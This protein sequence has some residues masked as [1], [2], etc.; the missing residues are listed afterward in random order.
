[1]KQKKK[2][3]FASYFTSPEKDFFFIYHVIMKQCFYK[4]STNHY[5][6]AVSPNTS[7]QSIGNVAF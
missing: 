2:G 6:S 3:K 7:G 1:M 5:S 4:R